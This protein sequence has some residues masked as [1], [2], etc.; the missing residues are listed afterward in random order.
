MSVS[1]GRAA[2][3]ETQQKQR[4]QGTVGIASCGLSSALMEDDDDLLPPP[5]PSP[6]RH[7]CHPAQQ[8][9]HYA[10]VIISQRGM[11]RERERD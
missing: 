4:R 2:A 5:L 8:I 9:P 10:S 1:V 11:R 7:D 6:H 3:A